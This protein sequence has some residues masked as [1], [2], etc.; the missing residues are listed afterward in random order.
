ML[1]QPPPEAVGRDSTIEDKGMGSIRPGISLQK[2][3]S[4]ELW[5]ES[6]WQLQEASGMEMGSEPRQRRFG[7]KPAPET[8]RSISLFKF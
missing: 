6:G 4:M 1:T 7:A 5:R 8:K 3:K 2:E